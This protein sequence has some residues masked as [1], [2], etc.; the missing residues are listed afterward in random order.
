MVVDVAK[1]VGTRYIRQGQVKAFREVIARSETDTYDL[2]NC[3]L[4][5]Q[6]VRVL[7]DFYKT[8]SF[9]NSKDETLNLYLRTNCERARICK[10]VEK[11]RLY[12]KSYSVEDLHE[13]IDSLTPGVVYEA[14][15]DS[16]I[17]LE[18]QLSFL[19][20]LILTRPEIIVDTGMVNRDLCE[21][22]RD[23]WVYKSKNH[24]V[25]LEVD[26]SNFI[27]RTVKEGYVKVPYRNE[28]KEETY[29]E[30]FTCIPASVG[31]EYLYE[32]EEF[33]GVVD[34]CFRILTKKVRRP[35]LIK[36]FI[37]TRE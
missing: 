14:R 1:E 29:R 12:P 31:R 7:E 17:A 34:K 16:R 27:E 18:W 15:V 32:D 2:A 9:I 3:R 19:T 28:L 33:S 6:A 13:Y 23:D 24:P 30:T 36:D 37:E 26:G 22:I 10:E 5:F 11:I 8:R 21:F 25:Y 4:C 20:L 35:K